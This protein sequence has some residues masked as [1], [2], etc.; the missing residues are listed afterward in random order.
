M[1]F[2]PPANANNPANN[3]NTITDCHIGIPKICLT[4]NPP[5]NNPRESQEI[6]I[7][8]NAYQ[9]SIFL[10]V[11]PY[12]LPMNSGMVVTLLARYLGANTIASRNR[13]TNAYHSKFP[14]TMPVLYPMLAN[15]N[16]M[17]GPTLV[18]HILKPMLYQLSDLPARNRVSSIFFFFPKLAL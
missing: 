17:E 3:T 13:N 6:N 11:S 9:A 15:A 14:A 1:A 18:P 8:I 10:V 5:A 7:L 12:L 2:N 16:S 4:K